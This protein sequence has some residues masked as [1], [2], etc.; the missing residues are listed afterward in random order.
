MN[1]ILVTGGC[2]F[3]GSNLISLLDRQGGWAVTVLDNESVGKRAYLDGLKLERFVVGDVRDPKA[4]AEA[5]EG[6]DVVVHLAAQ[7][8]VMPS[9]ETPEADFDVNA[10]GGLYALSAARDAKVGRF[11]FASSSAPLGQQPPPM[12]ETLA[13]RPSSPYGASKLAMEGY[14][15]AFH[16]SYGLNTAALRF[17]NV[18]GP[19]SKNKSSVV[20]AFIRN[21]LAGK[22]ITIYGDGAQ[23][24]D[25]L[26]VRDLCRM[27]MAVIEHPEEKGAGVFG[28][29]YQVGTGVETTVNHLVERLGAVV[30]AD[31]RFRLDVVHAEAR[32]AEIVRNYCDVSRFTAT[33]DCQAELSLDAG[34]AETWGYFVRAL[35]P[36]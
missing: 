23:T 2:G 32:S 7:T 1:K 20:A 17:A 5:T 28:Q 12:R 36:T 8:G 31:G 13:P 22:P 6:Q 9:I 33:F 34:L 10:R 15:S 25:F 30:A 19:G 14:C 11:I 27:I 26:H 24:R 16:H 21:I 3:I 18:Y 4:V 35:S 29:V